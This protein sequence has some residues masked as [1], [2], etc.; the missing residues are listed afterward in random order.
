MENEA[1]EAQA[2]GQAELLGENR[3]RALP[4]PGVGAAEVEQIGCMREASTLQS[5]R[6][7]GG[8]KTGDLVVA[9][10]RP[11]PATRRPQEDLQGVEPE[12]S[13]GR[14]RTGNASRS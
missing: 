11:L 4:E 10:D 14:G 8:A 7:A 5:S 9:D 12:R 13:S 6:G 1:C 3:C 2:T